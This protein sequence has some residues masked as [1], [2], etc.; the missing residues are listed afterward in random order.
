M[1]PPLNTHMSCSLFL[2]QD[3]PGQIFRSLSLRC[4][5]K[6]PL[7]RENEGEEGG[8]RR[9]EREE[10]RRDFR[11]R[12]GNCGLGQMSAYQSHVFEHAKTE[13]R[14]EIKRTKL[15]M[16][17]IRETD[18]N[19]QTQRRHHKVLAHRMINNSLYNDRGKTRVEWKRAEGTDTRRASEHMLERSR[20][21]YS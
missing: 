9:R 4:E 19:E 16:R 17:Q 5:G 14:D 8:R 2:G 7:K 1:S 6:N 10:K 21:K 3:L 12:A 15:T 13:E 11:R 18:P 20:D